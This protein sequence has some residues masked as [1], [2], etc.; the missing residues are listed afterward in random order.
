MSLKKVVQDYI[1]QSTVPESDRQP[2]FEAHLEQA[3]ALE[4]ARRSML[5][6]PV[7]T[8]MSLIMLVGTPMLMDY[9]WWAA[10]EGALLIF[11]GG[12]R[13]W[14]A[15]NFK[16]RYER[17]GERAIIQFSILTALQSLTLGVLAALVIFKYWAAQEV[18]LTIVLSAGVVAA[19][20]SALSVR[21][22]AHLIFLICVLGPFG[23]AIYLVGGLAKAA[24]IV[25]Y[26]LL[27][28]FL[29]QD[30]G[31]AK[32]AYIQRM[33]DYYDEQGRFMRL[34]NELRRLAHVVEQNP[35]SIAITNLDADIEYVNE[36]FQLSSGYSHGDLLGKNSRL[37]QSGKTPR[38]TYK[39]MWDTLIS[40]RAWKGELYNRRKDGSEYVELAFILPL[41]RPDGTKTHYVAIKEDITE[42]KQLAQELDDHRHH[43]E[44]LVE[45]RTEQLAEA[46]QQAEASNLAKSVFLAN[47]SHEIRTPMNAIVGFTHL[48]KRSEPRQG[49]MEPLAKIDAAAGH[50]LSIIN[51]V[52]D[53]AKIESGKLVLEQSD[54]RLEVLFDQI[55][56]MLRDKIKTSGL[57]FKV[58]LNDAPAWLRGD[59]TRL[60]QALLNY[61]GNAVKFTEQ[62]TITLRAKKIEERGDEILVRF[63]VQDTGIGIETDKKSGLFEAFEQADAS[64]TRKY[65]GTGLGL[66]ITR[67]LAQKMGGDTGVESVRG[68]GSTFWFT[69]WLWRGVEKIVAPAGAANAEASLRS[70]CSDSRILLVEDN[71]INSEVTCALLG[72]TGLVVD[73]AE[74]GIEAVEKVRETD[75]DLVLMDIQMPKMDGLE[76]TR[77]IRAMT[78]RSHLPILA[79]TA[80]VFQ[81]VRQEC[82]QA[83]MNDFVSKPVEPENLFSTIEKWLS[84]PKP[85]SY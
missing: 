39:S 18:V 26:L 17:L 21:R 78:N 8:V 47:M 50:L 25:G 16:C 11:L 29:V 19:S 52:L 24:L 30:G 4:L 60:R 15:R 32:H 73:T 36:A 82:L 9:G 43:L 54:F 33:K 72:N 65:G 53:L 85:V 34:Q 63:E 55:H 10:I 6:A 45:K 79:M 76:A 1:V 3:T 37:L 38:E 31:Q 44:E 12:I 23:F 71:L 64:T 27:M 56:S 81:E 40:G 61:V 67:L 14:F 83:G 49:Q 7:Y 2:D 58:D 13:V 77:L 22:S 57:T 59:Q 74:N 75:Y 69:A 70:H 51:D 68:Q 35:H 42:K 80:N 20:T 84:A 62:G 48:L 66:A 5:G 28:A 46:Q 41:S